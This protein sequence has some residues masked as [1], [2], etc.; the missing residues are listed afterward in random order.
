MPNLP[1]PVPT[2]SDSTTVSVWTLHY[3]LFGDEAHPLGPATGLVVVVVLSLVSFLVIRR[4]L[5]SLVHRTVSRTQVAWDDAL[6]ESNAFWWLSLLLPGVVTYVAIEPIQMEDQV[7]DWMRQFVAAGMVFAGMKAALCALDAIHK[8]SRSLPSLRGRPVK[9]YV[10]VVQIFLWTAGL[11]LTVTALFGKD[12]LALLT[13]VGALTAVLLLVFKDTI[14]SLV[15]SIQLTSNDMIRVGDWI[16]MPQ[17]KTDGDVIDVALH[18]VKVQNWDK[19]ISTIPTHKLIS[20]TFRNWRG[21]QESGGRRVKRAL[22]VDLDSVR[23]LDDADL[24]ILGE[25]HPDLSEWIDG[26]RKR[27]LDPE[28]ADAS[29]QDA[30]QAMPTNAGAYRAYAAKFLRSHPG[31]HIGMTLLVRALAPDTQGLP[32]ELY[33]FTRTTAWGEYENTQ[34]EIMDHLLAMLP[35]FDLVAFQRPAGGDVRDAGEIAWAAVGSDVTDDDDTA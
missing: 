29:P 28:A 27:L 19:T 14:L 25:R 22:R 17:A 20:E 26:Q 5:L 10:Q 30:R 13:G 11:L 4:A 18:T 21:M 7:R 9:G 16:S 15:A 12:P 35:A 31:V 2:Q 32:I 6:V 8:Y 24:T 3:W 34:G 33:F 23:F 1:I